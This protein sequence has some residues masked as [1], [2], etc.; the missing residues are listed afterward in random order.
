MKV[1]RDLEVRPGV[2]HRISVYYRPEA[3]LLLSKLLEEGDLKID[4]Y[5]LVALNLNPDALQEVVRRLEEIG[6]ITS[7]KRES[8]VINPRTGQ[9]SFMVKLLCSYCKSS[10][11]VKEEMMEHRDCGFIGKLSEFPVRKTGRACPKCGRP[12]NQVNSKRI[13]VWFSCKSCG[14]TLSKPEVGLLDTVSSETLTIEQLEVLDRVTYELNREYRKE[15]S[16]ITRLFNS[17]EKKLKDMG[18]RVEAPGRVKGASGV[19]HEFMFL[20]SR[21]EVMLGLDLV[22]G[23]N[24]DENMVQDVLRILTKHFDVRQNGIK[25][26]IMLAPR[27]PDFVRQFFMEEGTARGVV[28]IEGDTIEDL[29]TMVNDLDR[30][31]GV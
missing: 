24:D 11:I 28:V 20:A 22:I 3:R 23:D 7:S 21:G 15:V 19:E 10:S 29:T 31:L 26:V 6:V 14:Q 17:L 4:E 25:A 18:F 8:V 9:S 1:K 16:S 13:G 12:V 5:S 27:A 30:L 2:K